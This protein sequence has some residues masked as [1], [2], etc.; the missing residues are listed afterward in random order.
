MDDECEYDTSGSLRAESDNG[1]ITA[2][3]HCDANVD[4]SADVR[5][6]LRGTQLEYTIR[7]GEPY[8]ST[9]L[10]A[11]STDED[12]IAL[13]FDSIEGD[14]CDGSIFLHG[15]ASF[16]ALGE[17]A[18]VVYDGD[19]EV[20]RFELTVHDAA[21]IE[22]QAADGTDAFAL[23][24]SDYETVEQLSIASAKT[25]RMRVRNEAGER[26]LGADRFSWD[27]DDR[28]KARLEGGTG[29]RT[30]LEPLAVGTA[31]LT[32]RSSGIRADIA[33]EITDVDPSL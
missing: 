33:I 11:E 1:L 26:L 4:C 12:V 13:S 30:V 15:A 17:A 8:A 19:E 27:I 14:P 28:S 9:Q 24:E 3:V 20:D 32:V 23:A 7:V 5:A 6:V 2:A 31:T 29:V 16:D 10:R 22:L 21:R 18:V 25:L